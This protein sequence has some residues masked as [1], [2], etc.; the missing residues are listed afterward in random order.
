MGHS[1]GILTRPFD[2]SDVAAVLGTDSSDTG[3]LVLSPNINRRSRY[4]PY[5]FGSYN[6]LLIDKN[7]NENPIL[8]A[9]NFGMTPATIGT[10][11]YRSLPW[12]QYTRPVEGIHWL[13]FTDLDHYSHYAK[14]GISTARIY[15]N[16]PNNDRRFMF[17]SIGTGQG[18]GLI[19]GE[20]TYLFDKT[21]EILPSEFTH[22]TDSDLS[23][24][25][26]CFTLLFGNIQSGE[27]AFETAPWVTQS[28]PLS[29]LLSVDPSPMLLQ[30]ELDSSR[31]Q[32]IKDLMTSDSTHWIAIFCLAP[33]METDSSGRFVRWKIGNSQSSS[34]VFDEM[35]LISLDMWEDSAVQTESVLFSKDIDDYQMPAVM[36]TDTI[37]VASTAEY[38]DNP[39]AA[40]MPFTNRVSFAGYY[41]DGGDAWVTVDCGAFDSIYF[42]ENSIIGNLEHGFEFYISDSS[43]KWVYGGSRTVETIEN[44]NP[45]P[46]GHKYSIQFNDEFHEDVWV[47]QLAPGTYT[48]R[49]W[50]YVRQTGEAINWNFDPP[51]RQEM[52]KFEWQEGEKVFDDEREI[53]TTGTRQFTFTVS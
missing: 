40:G 51:H 38:L 42:P 24:A 14:G 19:K 25:E 36:Q 33:P 27:R 50:A 9:N 16:N 8:K 18:K 2:N 6:T 46:Y 34:L 44:P 31:S 47:P 39:D 10:G 3:T 23:F 29:E 52:A 37:G 13:R 49:L 41:D 5:A 28:E 1:Q 22:P 53:V 26:F 45:N 12:G 17:G 4:K 15:T 35:R 30:I 21:Y 20:A 43:G 11:P 32:E 7:G 48:I